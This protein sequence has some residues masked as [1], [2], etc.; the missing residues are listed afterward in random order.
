MDTVRRGPLVREVSGPGTLVPEEIR[1]LAAPSSAQVERVLERPGATVR[2]DTVV[3]VLINPQLELAALEA[4][5][6]SPLATPQ[7]VSNPPLR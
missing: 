6:S 5:R 7:A 2:A 1:W 4:E 3:V